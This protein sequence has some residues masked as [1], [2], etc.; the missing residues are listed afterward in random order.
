M[1]GA[2]CLGL[3]DDNV[4]LCRGGVCLYLCSVLIARIIQP[5]RTSIAMTE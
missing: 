1:C 2:F 4:A 3:S 5:G